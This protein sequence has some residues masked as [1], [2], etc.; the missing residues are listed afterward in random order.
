MLLFSFL[1]FVAVFQAHFVAASENV[2]WAIAGNVPATNAGG[3]MWTSNSSG[4]PPSVRCALLHASL[5]GQGTSEPVQLDG[6]YTLD[7]A[8]CTA[9]ELAA[10]Q[11]NESWSALCSADAAS[12]YFARLKV[13]SAPASVTCSGTPTHG[14][15][16]LCDC[17]RSGSGS[18]FMNPANGECVP[19][20]SGSV[21][22]RTVAAVVHLNCIEPGEPTVSRDLNMYTLHPCP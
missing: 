13:T 3:F 18:S 22:C 11:T 2:C 7:P 6:S 12:P 20:V 8:A 9:F 5:G 19:P 1:A 10:K 17:P 4:V 15:A 21:D 16:A 14:I